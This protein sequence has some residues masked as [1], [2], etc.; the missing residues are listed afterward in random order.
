MTGRPRQPHS[1]CGIC[2]RGIHPPAPASNRLPQ[3][4][5]SE[6][7]AFT[8]A[9]TSAATTAATASETSSV[10]PGRGRP[11]NCAAIAGH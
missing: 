11:C 8:A 4:A 9:T 10:S 3:P 7:G 1:G 6:F 2:F 5:P